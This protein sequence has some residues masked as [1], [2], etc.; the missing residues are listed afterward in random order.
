MARYQQ[1]ICLNCGEPLFVL[2]QNVYPEPAP[3]EKETPK[4]DASEKKNQK[5]SRPVDTEQTKPSQDKSS[6]ASASTESTNADEVTQE[7]TQPKKKPAKRDAV[8]IAKIKKPGKRLVT[9]FRMTLV[10]IGGIVAATIWYTVT[11]SN[12]DV[13]EAQMRKAAT[14]AFLALDERDVDAAA[15][16]F[17]KAAD[18]AVIAAPDTKNCQL[19]QQLQRESESAVNLSDQSILELLESTNSRRQSPD[20]KGIEK[21][22]TGWILFDASIRRVTSAEGTARI[23]VE[24][25]LQIESIPVTVTG[26]ESAFA[27]LQPSDADAVRAIFAAKIESIELQTAPTQQWIVKLGPDVVIWSDSRLYQIAGM[28]LEGDFDQQTDDQLSRQ[29][30]AI[31]VEDW[32]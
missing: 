29:K 30:Q 18:A 9:P 25:P 15:L 22:E 27:L 6:K 3:D 1:I 2:P 11:G 24:M 12:A 31:G 14:A 17:Q 20:W 13:A 5:P 4:A 21:I 19:L 26:P 7:A 32:K 23:A 10:A 8:P 16:Q 28:I